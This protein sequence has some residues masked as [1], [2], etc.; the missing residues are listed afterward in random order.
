ML[1]F[2]NHVLPTGSRIK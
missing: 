2:T 1:A